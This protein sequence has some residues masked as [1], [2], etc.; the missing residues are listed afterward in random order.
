MVTRRSPDPGVP[1]TLNAGQAL[2]LAAAIEAHT[3]NPAQAMRLDH[4]VGRLSPG[5]SADVIILDRNLFEVLIEQV[6]ATRVQRTWFA[7]RL[8]HDA[9][10][11]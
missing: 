11:P 8:V 9:T 3:V 5:L 7:G 2:D 10:T 4:E 6:H 1:G